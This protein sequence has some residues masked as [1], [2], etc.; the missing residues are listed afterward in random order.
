MRWGVTGVTE[1]LGRRLV[2]SSQ[3]EKRRQSHQLP[4]H[5]TPHGAFSQSADGGGG[6]SCGGGA[7][8]HNMVGCHCFIVTRLGGFV[9]P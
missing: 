9:H 7:H 1:R 6:G 8:Q 3:L 5:Q 2:R 4:V